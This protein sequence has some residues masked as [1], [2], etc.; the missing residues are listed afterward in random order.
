MQDI[1][2]KD[3]N[4]SSKILQIKDFLYAN[5]IQES[6]R[7]K[8]IF[9]AE[10]L[11][12]KLSRSLLLLKELKGEIISTLVATPCIISIKNS[13]ERVLCIDLMCVR[14]DFRRRKIA[15]DMIE[16][17]KSLCTTYSNAI[18][19]SQKRF[20]KFV[21]TDITYYHYPLNIKR[22]I[23]CKFFGDLTPV[24]KKIYLKLYTETSVKTSLNP[25]EHNNNSLSKSQAFT[26]KD[27]IKVRRAKREDIEIMYSKYI[28]SYNRFEIYR[29][30]EDIEE[31]RYW[32]L[33]DFLCTY[34]IEETQ[35]FHK[36]QYIPQDRTKV[37]DFFSFYFI[38]S[39]YI[40][41]KETFRGA[42]LYYYST[43]SISILNIFRIAIEKLRELKCDL[44]NCF[45]IMD[46]KSI[47]EAFK[48][49]KGT[50]NLKFFDYND[51]Y[52]RI[53]NEKFGFIMP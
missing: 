38:D 17:L 26:S 13:R 45:D 41:S 36:S 50:G 4:D 21:V 15:R 30:F 3:L 33:Q 49:V 18:Y 31:F 20:S 35:E 24:R 46:N 40:A 25:D 39:E 29:D 52:N 12:W 9:S 47:I 2:Y 23:E 16:K 28:E 44:I 19:L 34:V 1:F 14:K 42:Y 7:F 37:L 10:Y 43:T 51:R 53:S 48:L 8:L 6:D 5:F 11:L 27:S 32:L 22:L